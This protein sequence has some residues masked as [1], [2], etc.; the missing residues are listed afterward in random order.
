MCERWLREI[1]A[2]RQKNL[3][4]W[5]ITQGIVKSGSEAQHSKSG[6]GNTSDPLAALDAVINQLEPAIYLVQGFPPLH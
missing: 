6:S 3:F 4:D 1:A 5:T 2:A